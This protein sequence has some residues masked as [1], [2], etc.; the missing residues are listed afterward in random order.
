MN[1]EKT[2]SQQISDGL[3][4]SFEKLVR[5]TAKNGGELVFWRE[6]KIIYL[7]ASELLK[8]IENK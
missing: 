7:K 8:T 2:L 1:T 4:L 6:G 5:E 3:I